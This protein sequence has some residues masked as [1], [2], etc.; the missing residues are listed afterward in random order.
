MSQVASGG[1]IGAVVHFYDTHPISEQQILHDL[2]R[3]GVALEGLS[4]AVLQRCDQDHFGG[5][6]AVD[7]L[8][9]Q[10]G[11]G[12]G[13]HVLDVCSGLGEPGALPRPSPRL[14]GADAFAAL[15]LENGTQTFPTEVLG[16]AY[17]LL[18]SPAPLR[19]GDFE[20]PLARFELTLQGDLSYAVVLI[21]SVPGRTLDLIM[22]QLPTA[23]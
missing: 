12:A 7:L 19:P 20:R 9:D 18:V 15:G 8:A 10:A 11:I 16:A 4:E 23:P 13:M 5:L 6:E 14:P 22:L 3:D 17:E 1:A 2:A 21:G